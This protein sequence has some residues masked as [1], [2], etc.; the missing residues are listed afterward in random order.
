MNQKTYTQDAMAR[1]L[2]DDRIRDM[3][4]ASGP[5]NQKPFGT[6]PSW[7]NKPF[8]GSRDVTVKDAAVAVGLTAAAAVVGYC[9]GVA[10]AK[11]YE[12]MTQQS[13]PME[14]SEIIKL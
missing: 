4:V 11:A 3:V 2:A 8:M 9:I 13:D 14:A 7:M 6:Q 10:I 1:V 12:S 5:N